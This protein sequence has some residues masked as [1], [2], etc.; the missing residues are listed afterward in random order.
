MK[1]IKCITIICVLAAFLLSGCIQDD[2]GDCTRICNLIIKIVDENGNDITTTGVVN[3]ATLYLFDSNDK[4]LEQIEVPASTI[5]S[6]EAIKLEYPEHPYLTAVV[7]CNIDDPN[8]VVD[9]M[10]PAYSITSDMDLYLAGSRATAMSGYP[11]EL[12]HG[13]QVIP[14]PLSSGSS[15]T[16]EIIVSRKVS[17]IQVNVK[18]LHKSFPTNSPN[19]DYRFEVSG[20]SDSFELI[21]GRLCSDAGEAIYTPQITF[22]GTFHSTELFNTFPTNSGE[23]VMIKIYRNNVLIYTA[24]VDK[25][26]N[27]FVAVEGRT[28][29]VTIDFSAAGVKIEGKVMPWGELNQIV[30]Q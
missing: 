30:T 16:S 9:P 19:T 10:N 5:R 7:W 11:S 29:I 8:I 14:I 15:S 27:K 3:Q 26:G 1:I 22:D 13:K 2:R 17:S 24:T 4:F 18:G 6:R 28:L 20:T 25:D 23:G 12:F 21:E